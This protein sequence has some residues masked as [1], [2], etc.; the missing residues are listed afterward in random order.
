MSSLSLEALLSNPSL[1]EEIPMEDLDEGPFFSLEDL[2]GGEAVL[3]TRELMK[4]AT[5]SKV[6]VVISVCF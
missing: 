4:D 1:Y 6:V 5:P 2:F 3:G